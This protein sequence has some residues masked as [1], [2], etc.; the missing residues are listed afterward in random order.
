[1]YLSVKLK[2]PAIVMVPFDLDFGLKLGT[3]TASA[4]SRSKTRVEMVVTIT[5]QFFDSVISKPIFNIGD[6][7]LTLLKN[8]IFIMIHSLLK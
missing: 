6:L 1:M 7:F 2:C 5:S 8:F 4:R 3:R